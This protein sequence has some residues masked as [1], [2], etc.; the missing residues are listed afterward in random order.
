MTYEELKE[1]QSWTLAQKIDHTLGVI[2]QFRN[3]YDG[4]V[5]VA[6]SG[7]KDSCVMLN[8]VELIIPNVPCMFIMTGC[9]SPSVCRFVR[10]MKQE[11]HNI[12]MT[13]PRKTLK[14]VFAE[15]GFPLVSKK[16]AHNIMVVRRNP[17]TVTA[18]RLIDPKNKHRIP[19]N[20]LYLLNEPYEVSDRCCYWLKKTPS[21]D[22]GKRTGCYPFIGVLASESD[23]RA[24]GYIQ[25]GG[26]NSFTTTTNT[27]P[28]SWPLAIWNEED[29][30]A[31]IKDRGL[32]IP[33]IYEKGATRTGCMGCGFGAHLD[34]STLNVLQRL[35]PKWY[36]MMM[37]YENNGVR[38][39]DAL[40]KAVERG[41][42]FHKYEY[43]TSIQDVPSPQLELFTDDFY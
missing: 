39:G 11:G 28:S 22:Y 29:I 7:G 24:A 4:K 1:R 14:Q 12:E 26:C 43:D 34:C 2:E 16:T 18:K 13:K 10:Q 32:K 25:R 6:F 31:Y 36:K 33:D 23:S 9:E 41:R 38:Y 21:Y 17:D 35:W 19:S 8:L 20:W 40:K 5:Y 37:N 30:W 3:H 42:K 15:C 27:H